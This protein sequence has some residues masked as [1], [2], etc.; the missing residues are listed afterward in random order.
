M[1]D[2]A[3][4]ALALEGMLAKQTH[5]KGRGNRDAKTKTTAK[6]ENKGKNPNKTQTV[7]YNLKQKK[8]NK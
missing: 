1:R 2:T 3:H 4:I 6:E 7:K 8:I 5:T